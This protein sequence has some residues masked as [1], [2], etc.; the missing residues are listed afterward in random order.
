[1][2]IVRARLAPIRL[3]LR[4]PLGTGRG[5]IFERRGVLL[6]FDT[7]D[8][9]SGFG[10]ATP[11]EG[12][13]LESAEAAGDA[14][15]KLA[16][17]ALGRDPREAGPLLD[18]A[19]AIAPDRP[20][21]RFA[22]DTALRDLAAQAAGRSLAG[23]L[24]QGAFPPRRPRSRVAVNALLVARDPRA[25]AA[26]AACAVRDGFRTLKLKLGGAAFADDLARVAAVRGAVGPRIAL[27]LDANGAWSADEA[28]AHALRLAPFD[29]EWIEQPVPADD[30]AG[31]ARVRLRTGLRIAAD[32]AATTPECVERLLSAGAA[33]VL[34]LK[35]AV[36]GGLRAS[37]RIATCARD[38]GVAVVV[39]TILD[40]AV[41]RAAARA[42]A[43]SLPHPLPAC[44]LATA[45]LLATD[46][47]REDAPRDGFL[48]MPIVPGL[49]V[50]VD[51]DRL[52]HVT[53]GSGFELRAD[54]T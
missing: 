54:V 8:G 4:A 36:A 49:G 32:E 50:S 10:E 44:G 27:R 47:A 22:F 42:F 38:A 16:A 18:R 2:R 20:C 51:P 53:V 25:A 5:T 3:R 34:V 28:V 19:E 17:V 7:V 6:R 29:P 11:V 45:D 33:D 46:L 39:T 26:E 23:E 9:R 12:F 15:A 40:G 21:A 48:T 13:G 43:A 37:E 30:V 52:S 14:L 35:P 24:A 1:M 31:L 41:G